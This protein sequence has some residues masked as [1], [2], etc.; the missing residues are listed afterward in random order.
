MEDEISFALKNF[1]CQKVEIES[2]VNEILLKFKLD[3]YR[4][5][6]PRSLSGGEKQRVALASI[7]AAQPQILVLD[8]PTRGM[9][10][11]LKDELMRL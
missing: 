9:Q 8:E 2:R 4:K 5:R 10:Q 1:G 3:A 7:L 11:G 6:Y